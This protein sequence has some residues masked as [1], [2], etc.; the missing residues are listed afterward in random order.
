MAASTVAYTD[1]TGNKDYLG[2]IASQIGRRLK[3]ASDMASD[4]R[5]YAEKKA[6]EGGTSLSEAG[7]GRGYFFK[8]ALGSRF[9]GDAIARTKGRMGV[10]GAGTDPTGNFKS[11]FRGGFDY[12]VTNEIQSS[13][14]APL[15]GAIV[16]GLRGVEG[17]LLAVGQSIGQLASGMD[18]LARAQEDA[19]K[20]AIM[21]G[22]FMQAFLNF[23]Q[24]E[25]SRQRAQSEEGVL[26]SGQKLL[27]G[28]GGAGLL[29]GRGMINVTPRR[30]GGGPG[31]KITG[32]VG[33]SLLSLGTSALTSR[34]SGKYAKQI[35]L[36]TGLGT[37][38]KTGIYGSDVVRAAGRVAAGLDPTTVGRNVAKLVGNPD[39]GSMFAKLLTGGNQ[40][41]NA[42]ETFAGAAAAVPATKTGLKQLDMMMDLQGAGMGKL[43]QEMADALTRQRGLAT[44]SNLDSLLDYDVFRAMTD[45]KGR[46]MFTEKQAAMFRDLG[47]SAGSKNVARY[48]A[49][50]AKKGVGPTNMRAAGTSA[51]GFAEAIK[52]YYKNTT[53]KNLDDAVVLT[54]FARQLDKGVKPDDAVKFIRKSFG[55][56][57]ADNVLIK[58]GKLAAQNSMV[59]KALG[60]AAGRSA[61]KKLP[62]IG[63][64]LGTA[65]AI[66][67]L[68]K[69]DFLGAGLEFSSGMLGLLPGIGSG[70][71]FGIDGFL[72]ARDMGMTPLADGGITARPTNALIGEA[73]KEG[74][75]PLEGARGRKTFTMFGEGVLQAR[76]DNKSDESEL[77]ALGHKRYYEGMGGWEKFGEGISNFFGNAKD[78]IGET[79]DN[80][81]PINKIKETFNREGEGDKNQWWDF[82]DV[83][84]NK[85][86]LRNPNNANDQANMLNDV[87]AQT[88]SNSNISMPTTVVN[89]YNA[90]AGGEGGG[91]STGSSAF[92]SDYAV[93]AANYSLATKA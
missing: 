59:S 78:K 14:T 75:F 86:D 1:T 57:I 54:E 28:S 23:M 15:T 47:L 11:R 16:G 22:A 68:R 46:K 6:E 27:R 17:G 34:A 50:M 55:S 67:R 85:Q 93:F 76:K 7:I 26:E 74:V 51:E 36:A 89:N 10:G 52:K 3:E 20:Q 39:T 32:G 41:V 80:L 73:G 64:V 53:F 29:G 69:G 70:L 37:T 5:G 40:A 88:G 87:S 48:K 82:M 60:K 21:N 63:A 43:G 58:G 33:G 38:A 18:D 83:F 4:E 8:R 24:R 30:G 19:A 65:F 2:S 9:G 79:L 72:L 62:L 91:D 42:A 61:L 31:D 45:S 71:G 90:V 92:P 44:G 56:Q 13:V 25:G 35:G 81:N 66:D 12:N 77:T 49:R 84:P